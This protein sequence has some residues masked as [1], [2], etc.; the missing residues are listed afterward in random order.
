[1]SKLY[2]A[3]LV[4][5]A[6]AGTALLAS[7]GCSDSVHDEE[8]GVALG[9]AGEADAGDGG[10]AK[11]TLVIS[12]VFPFGGRTGAPFKKDY[13]EILNKSSKEVTLDGLSLQV[14]TTA[15]SAFSVAVP[16]TGK[17]GPGRYFLVE[18]GGAA[19]ETGEALPTPDQPGAADSP[20]IGEST[21]SNVKMA[22]KV[23]LA[24]GTGPLNCGQLGS[25]CAPA[26]LLDLVGWGPASAWEGSTSARSFTD[27]A[28]EADKKALARPGTSCADS[29]NNGKD[30]NLA[31]PDPRNG[32][33]DAVNC[34][35]PKPD[36]GIDAASIPKPP[37]EPDPGKELP[38]DAG[39]RP[40]ASAGSGASGGGDD[41]CSV[42]VTGAGDL[43]LSTPLAGLA[44][45]ALLVARRRRR[46][47]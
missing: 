13:V 46:D 32:E 10:V 30:F 3:A 27:D 42:G 38:F 18:L 43:A 33:K 20:S 31:T 37:G 35:P 25:Q 41:G 8:T 36:A 12:A 21:T 5:G 45:A 15:T 17:V 47:D 14:S 22:G 23:A 2:A 9:A 39:V 7:V 29:D 19:A 26:K 24:Q 1:M 44:L 6:F 16:L 28:S 40:D 34:N 11:G 4:L